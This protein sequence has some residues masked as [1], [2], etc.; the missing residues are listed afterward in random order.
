MFTQ[1]NSTVFVPANYAFFAKTGA[2]RLNDFFS[3]MVSVTTLVRKNAT[4]AGLLTK[5]LSVISKCNN[6]D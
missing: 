5:L 1:Q 6:S 2:T 3:E 4:A